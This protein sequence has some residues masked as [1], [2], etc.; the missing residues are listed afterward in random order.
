MSVAAI[1]LLQQRRLGWTRSGVVALM[2][3]LSVI[4]YFD[5]TI[6]SIA[7]PSMITE[8]G[9]TPTQMGTVYSAF[10][11]SYTLLMI[12]GGRL[13]DRFGPRIVLAWMAFGSALFTALVAVA[14]RPGLGA[15]FG[16]LPSLL[17]IRLC[18]GVFTAPLYPTCGKMNANWA[19][20]HLRARVQGFIN[21]GAGVGGAVSPI[22]FAALIRWYGWR[23]AFVIAGVVTA[24]LGLAW[25]V[26]VRD[27][28]TQHPAL[29]GLDIE[30]PAGRLED[31][32]APA[33]WGKLLRNR[34]LRW[35]TAGYVMVDYFEYIFFYWI[36]YYLGEV[37][38]LGPAES[39]VYTTILFAAWVLLTPV[40]GWVA[41]RMTRRLGVRQ[42]L[43]LFAISTLAGSA[44][45][46]CVGA[47]ASGT[48]GAVSFMALALALT[49]C[50]DV[51]F[52]TATIGISGKE[53]GAAGAIM[54]TGGNAGGFLA[55]IVTPLIAA[56]FGW[57]AALYFGSL[58][59]VAALLTW[60]PFNPAREES[61]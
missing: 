59:A 38:H 39:A 8:F 55:P 20:A 48:L 33:P 54:N 30:N 2:F 60:L 22:I 56:R 61:A 32:R 5:R 11:L 36:Y 24:L 47:N 21:A 1:T 28:P 25:V 15:V 14:G 34:S 27:Y 46:L 16:I 43:R 23:I 52:W 26:Y 31:S 18:A 13:A 49:S 10:L 58:V 19:P 44:V 3:G 45:L 50:A 9:I 4:S 42:G 41:D 37:R 40:G 17:L 7:G 12:P 29:R 6:M 35:L 51:A 53:V 57:S